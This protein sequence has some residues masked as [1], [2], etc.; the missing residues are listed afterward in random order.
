MTESEAGGVDLDQIMKGLIYS[1]VY[2]INYNKAVKGLKERELYD[3]I[4]FAEWSLELPFG[5]NDGRDKIRNEK[6]IE[7]VV[8][9][10]AKYYGP[11]HGLS[12]GK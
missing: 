12:V 3:H 10:Y 4:C 11:E 5:D 6:N 8:N 2:F 9:V 1:E 7:E